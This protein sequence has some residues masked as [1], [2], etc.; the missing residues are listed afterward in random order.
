MK[1]LNDYAIKSG[2]LGKMSGVSLAVHAVPDAFLLMHTGVGCKYKAASQIAN[3]DWQVHPN[4]REGWT[5]VGDRALIKGSAERIGP[6]MRTWSQRRDPAFIAMVTATFL[7]MTGEDFKAAAQKAA[8]YLEC[9]CAVIAT[10]GFRGDLFEGYAQLLLELIRQVD[11]DKKP[12]RPKEVGLLGYFFDRYEAD[13]IGNLQQIRFLLN[14]IGLNLGPSM[15]S[16]RPYDE[17]MQI[18]RCGLLLGTPYLRPIRADVDKICSRPLHSVDLPLGLRGTARWVRQ[19]AKAA[20]VSLE[21]ADKFISGQVSYAKSRLSRL[22]EEHMRGLEVAVFAETPYAAGVCSMLIELNLQPILIGLRDSS[23]G[24]V[25]EFQRILKADGVELPDKAEVLVQPSLRL[26]R[27]KFIELLKQHRLTGIFGTSAELNLLSTISSADLLEPESM[28]PPSQAEGRVF[29]V[30]IG[31]PSTSHHAFH[32]EPL[33]GFGGAV[34]F[35]QRI[36]QQATHYS[37]L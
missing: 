4:R 10:E 30:E 22:S 20:K 6:Y 34:V 9:P 36:M 17:L 27:S 18:R 5:E 25:E 37:L 19:V 11:W 13:H 7:Q 14:G 12:S 15:L 23:L 3:H 29:G 32:A 28:F 1:S 2:Q 24:G 33:M 26:I 8:D 16:G 35:A 21:R 31:F